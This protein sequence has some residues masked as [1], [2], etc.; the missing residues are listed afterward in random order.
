MRRALLCAVAIAAGVWTPAAVA[1]HTLGTCDQTYGTGTDPQT[2]V[3]ASA[4]HQTICFTQGT[5]NSAKTGSYEFDYSGVNDVI[6]RATSGSA[7]TF[8]GPMKVGDSADRDEWYGI[9]LDA[10]SSDCVDDATCTLDSTSHYLNGD[11]LIFD[12]VNVTNG[13]A[14]TSCFHT[15]SDSASQADNVTV[16]YSRIYNCGEDGEHDHGIYMGHGRNWSI[17]D[18]YCYANGSR[19]LATHADGSGDFSNNVVSQNCVKH[20]DAT[21]Y[22]CYAQT[23]F[24]GGADNV[25]IHDNV[26]VYPTPFTGATFWNVAVGNDYAGG[27]NGNSFTDNCVRR[28][29]G[30]SGINS[31]VAAE[32]ITVSGNITAD[33]DFS[34][35]FL[36]GWQGVVLQGRNYQVGE[37]PGSP[38]DSA[39]LD[40]DPDG[41]VGAF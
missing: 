25:D 13:G 37:G 10:T 38:G 17:H 19:C 16:R 41:P 28:Q 15:G 29:D 27:A 36:W 26:I 32:G 40:K 35:D 20:Q 39:C 3:N 22:R 6:V 33:P 21:D 7:V 23:L 34:T 5:Y 18:N 2:V 9:R 1:S 8:A 4:D 30:A 11:D 24:S 12:R 31:N 14:A